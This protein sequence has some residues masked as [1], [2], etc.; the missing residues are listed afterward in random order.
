MTNINDE[1]D[2]LHDLHVLCK[3]WQ[4][5][6][7]QS[8]GKFKIYSPSTFIHTFFAFNS[9]Y[10]NKWVESF[11]KQTVGHW[12]T[13]EGQ[14]KPINSLVDFC[15]DTL[16]QIAA[17]FFLDELN[18]YINQNILNDPTSLLDNARRISIPSPYNT[19]E[20][21][22]GALMQAFSKLHLPQEFTH[23]HHKEL[24]KF[25]Y[26]VRCNIF[27]GRK[28]FPQL[29]EPNQEERLKIYTGILLATNE[30]FF[31]AAEKKFNWKSNQQP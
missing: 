29:L 23:G 3:E 21:A 25:V 17:N 10:S 13:R 12:D 20:E 5:G 18:R 30:V 11:D 31:A 28:R 4:F 14:I 6:I 8:G 15:Y 16:G 22:H 24:V 7:K 19:F 9:I 27:H 1:L 26:L 2:N